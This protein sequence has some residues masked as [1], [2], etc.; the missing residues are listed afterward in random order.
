MVTP[1]FFNTLKT[2]HIRTVEGENF[3]NVPILARNVAWLMVFLPHLTT[4]AFGFNFDPDDLKFLKEYNGCLKGLSNVK[5]LSLIFGFRFPFM[6]VVPTKR[7]TR[8]VEQ[9]LRVTNQLEKLEIGHSNTVIATRGGNNEADTGFLSALYDRSR[10]S[11]REIRLL[12]I[13]PDIFNIPATDYSIFESLRIMSGD[14]SCFIR[15]LKVD[16]DKLPPNLEVLYLPFYW[17]RDERIG[18]DTFLEEDALLQLVT[19]GKFSK[20]KEVVVP[21]QPINEA[22]EVVRTKAHRNLWRKIKEEVEGNEVFRSGKIKFRVLDQGEPG[23]S[24]CNLFTFQSVDKK[25]NY[26]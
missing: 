3:S 21:S 10:N 17:V 6:T 25:L 14:V 20:L 8:G 23:E 16:Q 1:A 7:R 15:L 22:G 5:E 26:L 13:G 19:S 24:F 18:E 9:L 11:L 2:L 4:A 12:K